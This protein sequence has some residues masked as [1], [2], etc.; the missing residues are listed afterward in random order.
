VQGPLHP[1]LESLLAQ[2]D[3]LLPLAQAGL[4][5]A[6]VAP[7]LL[8]QDGPRTYLILAQNNHE[9]R[10]TGGFIS[11]AGFVRLA[12][13]QITELKLSDSYSVD[14]WQQPH[15]PA[16]GSPE[17]ADGRTVA[18]AAGQQLVARLPGDRGC[19]ARPVCPGSGRTG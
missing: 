13:G 6:Q 7:A 2:V 18:H 11:G 1:R 19:G 12:G 5:A 3:Q 10:P 16:P 14:N 4:Q 9:L 8:G 15:P 17:R